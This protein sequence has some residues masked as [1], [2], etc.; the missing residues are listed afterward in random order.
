MSTFSSE[1]DPPRKQSSSFQDLSASSVLVICPE[2]L[3][4]RGVCEYA[5]LIAN[6]RKEGPSEGSEECNQRYRLFVVLCVFTRQPQPLASSSVAQMATPSTTHQQPQA[7]LFPRHSVLPRFGV[8]VSSITFPEGTH[9]AYC[10]QK[11]PPYNSA[12]GAPGPGQGPAGQPQPGVSAA[13]PDAHRRGLERHRRRPRPQRAVD[14]WLCPAHRGGGSLSD[15][16]L[17]G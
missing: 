8:W 2:T 12:R 9:D 1:L 5:N 4:P 15:S 14:V 10:C 7:I 16:R 6:G 11:E 3:S 13:L 17:V